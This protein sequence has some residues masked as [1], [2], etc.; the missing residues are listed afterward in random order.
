MIVIIADGIDEVVMRYARD[1]N[2]FLIDAENNNRHGYFICLSCHCLSHWRK[3]SIDQRR[4]HFYHAEANE[5]CPLS[6]IGGVGIC[7]M[8]KM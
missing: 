3:E 7:W 1:F 6:I 5:D 4:P 2:G 8:M